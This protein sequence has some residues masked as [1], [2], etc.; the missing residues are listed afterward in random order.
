MLV[1][2]WLA[3]VERLCHTSSILCQIQRISNCQK[4]FVL[5]LHMKKKILVLITG[6]TIAA[7]EKDGVRSL[8]DEGEFCEKLKK[9]GDLTSQ[10]QIDISIPFYTFSENMTIAKWQ[11][12]LYSIRQSMRTQKYDAIILTHGSDTI[13][14]TANLLAFATHGYNIP[15]VLVASAQPL[16]HIQSNGEINFR[17]ALNFVVRTNC[18]GTFVAYS[19]D[20]LNTTIYAGERVLQ[21]QPFVDRYFSFASKLDFGVVSK[22]GDFSCT[23]LELCADKVQSIDVKPLVEQLDDLGKIGGNVLVVSLHVGLDFSVF[24]LSRVDAV[25]VNPYHSSSYCLLDDGSNYS[26][27]LLCDNCNKYNVPLLLSPCRQNAPMYNTLPRGIVK[28]CN[29]S[30]EATFAKIL[31]ANSLFDAK[32]TD[33]IKFLTQ[34]LCSEFVHC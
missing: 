23:N 11:K 4:D 9:M 30:S 34:P 15:I 27:S 14:L 6:G 32:S 33:W 13:A 24:D 12:I 17:A 20:N 7:V 25:I 10:A 8:I 5:N 31:C 26:I 3:V 2:N 29:I 16:G 21:S 22:D 28:L 1:R 18:K 19:Y